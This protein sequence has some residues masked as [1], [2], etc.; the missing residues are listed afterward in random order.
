VSRSAWEPESPRSGFSAP[1]DDV[2]HRLHQLA[3][4]TTELG[5][6][7]TLAEVAEAAVGHF[8]EAIRAA[9]A[10]LMVRSGDRLEMIA[11]HGLQRGITEMW[12][13]F[14]IEHANPAS[15]AAREGRV[16]LLDDVAEIERRYPSLRGQM[17][18][19]RSLVNLPLGAGPHNVGAIGLTFEDGWLPGRRELAFLTTFAEACGQAIRR[20]R[21]TAEATQQ[22]R[23]LAFLADASAELASSLDPTETLG[24]I[25]RL[26]VP[27]LAEWCAV[28]VVRDGALT[29]VAVAH[30][31]P[32]KVEWAWELERRYPGDPDAP[33]GAHNVFRTGR[34]ELYADIPDEMLVAGAR[35][36]EHLRLSREL[37]L[38][39]AVI[40]PL[41]ARGRILGVITLI[42]GE[43]GERFGPADLALAED[44]ARRAAVSMDNAQ[45]H[46]AAQDVAV[47]LGRAVLPESLDDVPGWQIAVH[48]RPGGQAEVGGDFY[49]AVPTPEGGLAFFVGDVMGHGLVAAAAMAQM[50]AALRAYLS[51]DPEP[52]QVMTRM[53]A[54]FAN[55]G[56][57]RLVSLL[58][59]V[60]GP[61]GRVR[62]VNAGHH[63]PLVVGIDGSTRWITSVPQRP[64]GVGGDD[65]VVTE[66]RVAA[67]DVVLLF[68]DGL[69]ERR[70]ESIDT[71]LARLAEAA[72]GLAR[73]PGP[74]ALDRLVT[75]VGL[76]GGEDDV[77]ALTLRRA[78]G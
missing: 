73:S 15:E 40:V 19:G 34:S 66:C 60:I 67:D 58:Y 22:A 78:P 69:V 3:E 26:A 20:I 50:R 45:L 8:A 39:S 74:G 18:Q 25:A 41:A 44:L 38:R 12:G 17:P 9:V 2:A 62:L 48:Y 23:Q 32:A 21:A 24:R 71:G 33:A 14:G 43:A 46:N 77:T 68:T 64:L 65:R 35:D 57:A 75:Q 7:E 1:D 37:H 29:T 52:S 72:S 59:G 28:Q 63:R 56:I 10:T 4:V 31:D 36:E 49:D 13:S 30:A 55:L 51:I 47:Q 6:A 27:D 61:D 16:I 76:D 53:D 5:W 54:M 70:D 42:R 11:G